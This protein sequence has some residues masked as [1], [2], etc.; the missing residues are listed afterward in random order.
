MRLTSFTDFGLR[1]LM[2]LAAQPE[3]ALSV[4]A[5]ARELA[6]SAHHLTKVV[7]LLAAGG[8]VTTQRGAGGGFRLARPPERIL[9]GEAVRLLE[10]RQALVACFRPDGGDCALLPGC[11]LKHRLARAEAAFLAELD[12]ATL[13]DIAHPGPARRAA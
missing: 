2:R 3:R 8:L 9:L 11:G 10:G 7:R 12:R 13:A 5:L 4:A 6:I 1:A